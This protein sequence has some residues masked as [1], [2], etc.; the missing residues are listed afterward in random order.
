VIHY[1][2]R[3]QGNKQFVSGYI[4]LSKIAGIQFVK[5]ITLED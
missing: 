1:H 3:R 2:P 4:I 5:K